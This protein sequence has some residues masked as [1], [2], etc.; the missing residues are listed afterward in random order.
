M[1]KKKKTKDIRDTLPKTETGKMLSRKV[2]DY[3][4][5][6]KF[7]K[8]LD[9]VVL[10]KVMTRYLISSI[11]DLRKF[12]QGRKLATLPALD[13]IIIKGLLEAFEDGDYTKLEAFIT[14]AV[15]KPS[16]HIEVEGSV[17]M[18][19]QIPT[20]K[21]AVKVI[22]ADPAYQLEEPGPVEDL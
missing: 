9:R 16:E 3:G 7:L 17:D 15:G 13:A 14:R 20:F 5:D 21:E 4:T 6:L 18:V 11:A 1:P 2:D 10:S 12:C 19:H 22:E 8:S